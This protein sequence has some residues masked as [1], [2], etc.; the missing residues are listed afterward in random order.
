MEFIVLIMLGPQL[1]GNG[2]LCMSLVASAPITLGVWALH[3]YKQEAPKWSMAT[4]HHSF[5]LNTNLFR[6]FAAAVYILSVNAS[7]VGLVIGARNVSV[8]NIHYINSGHWIWIPVHSSS[9]NRPSQC[10]PPTSLTTIKIHLSQYHHRLLMWH[11]LTVLRVM[12]SSWKDHLYWSWSPRY[13]TKLKAQVSSMLLVLLV[14]VT[15][16]QQM[17]FKPSRQA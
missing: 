11:S 3:G 15:T 17:N 9:S 8:S 4:N 7:K 5:P 12:G 6:L 1:T 14:V 13:C 2:C 10:P 16:P